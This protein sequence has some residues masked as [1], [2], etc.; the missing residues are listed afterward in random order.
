MRAEIRG[1]VARGRA[2]REDGHMSFQ[3][4]RDLSGRT[5]LITGASGG[6]GAAT[7]VEFARR[8]ADLVL[9]AHAH[10]EGMR[11]AVARCEAL[12]A[13][14]TTIVSDL[15]D[16]GFDGVAVVDAAFAAQPGLDVF[17]SCAGAHIDLPFLDMTAE[18]FDRTWRL[19]VRSG[20]LIALA[21]ARGWASAGTAGRMVFVGS[22]NGDLSEATS[23]AYDISKAA[24]HGMVRTL[25]VELAPRGIRVNGIAP[26]LI[27]TPATS[28]LEA[29]PEKAAWA[30]SHTPNG[31][32][33]GPDGCAAGIAF[34]VSDAAEHIQGHIL[35]VDGGLSVVQFPPLPD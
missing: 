19:N 6:L 12:G 32:V 3:Q 15:S 34:L 27:R 18:R 10:D 33:P 22:I 29:S 2:D 9:H 25:C 28:W 20:Y 35:R 21:L 24:V 14:V 8:G 16:P 26:G 17:V 30:E 23:T 31:T 13:R 7:A 5:A 4:T 11:G 1:D